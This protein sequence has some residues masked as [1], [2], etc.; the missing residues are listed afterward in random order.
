[1]VKE[2]A[3]E[4]VIYKD[5]TLPSTQEV[6]QRLQAIQNFQSLVRKSLK[7][8]HDFGKIPGCDKP[9][10]LKPG[11]EKIAK[12]LGLSDE[13]EILNSVEDWDKPFFHYTVKCTLRNI[14]SGKIVSTGLGSC[15]SKESKYRYRWVF[16]SE[17]PAG[18][19]KNTLVKKLKT[20]KS[21]K[22][23]YV[24]RIENDDIYSQVNTL[25][26]MAKK[27]S[28]VDAALSAGRLSELFTQDIEE[29]GD[30]ID[31]VPETPLPK[32]AKVTENLEVQEA[33][34]I[35][36]EEPEPTAEEIE[37]ES[38]RLIKVIHTLLSVTK[39]PDEEYREFLKYNFNKKSSKELT[40][41][42]KQ[43]VVNW[44]DDIAGVQEKLKEEQ[45]EEPTT[46]EE[47]IFEN[48]KVKVYIAPR[49]DRDGNP[50][51]ELWFEKLPG[52]GEEWVK[53]GAICVSELLRKHPKIAKPYLSM[54][55][56]PSLPEKFSEILTE[57]MERSK[58]EN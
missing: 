23:Y 3:T 19:A 41:D 14:A 55:I 46:K 35:V 38:K 48:D 56:S 39:V 22:K 50:I 7:E 1:M 36:G 13:Y 25:L 24:Y 20:A 17:V 58:N 52:L 12:L 5:A 16:E 31:I 45:K 26:K 4:V 29:F 34:E 57:S 43:L 37:R 9:S 11:A 18:I 47:E 30:V 28:L 51:P 49:F 6:K 2:K 53:D 40:N 33:Q 15:N 21:G 42:E 32:D 54:V 10:L 44:L 8:G 27:R